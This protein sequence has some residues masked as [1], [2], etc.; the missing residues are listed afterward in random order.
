MYVQ[1]VDIRIVSLITIEF[2]KHALTS[3]QITDF[4]HLYLLFIILDMYIYTIF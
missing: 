2:N 3:W 4:D 1:R